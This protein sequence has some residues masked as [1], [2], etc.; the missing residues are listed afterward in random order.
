MKGPA[1]RASVLVS[2]LLMTGA[3]YVA[4]A[5]GLISS[6]LVAR[7]L[8]PSDYG[9]YAYVLWLC[10]VLVTLM[11][12]G[13]TTSAIRF[14]SESRGRGDPA[15]ADALHN[16]FSRGQWISI[17]VVLVGFVAL[18]PWL[19][20]SGW[21]E[22][23]WLFGA[24]VAVATI[25]KTRYVFDVSICKGHSRF[26]IE[27]M[28]IS[29]LAMSS[30]I[31][32][33]VLWF[34]DAPLSSYLLLFTAVCI[35]HP[36]FSWWQMRRAGI[37]AAPRGPDREQLANVYPHLYWTLVL[38]L[39]GVLGNRTAETF[40]LNRYENAESIAFFSIA[41]QLTRA[42][43][44]MLSIG[45]TTVLMPLMAHGFGSGGQ[46]KAQS[47]ASD[48][49]RS[50]HFMGMLLVGVGLLWAEPIVMLLYGRAYQPAV[51]VLQ[52]LI[53][54]GGLTLSLAALGSLLSVT[55]NQRA[56]AVTAL[57]AMVTS[58]V[59]ALVLVPR[60]GLAGAVAS[61]AAASFANLLIT[62]LVVRKY[63][64][65]RMPWRE[66][67]RLSLAAVVAFAATGWVLALPEAPYA[68]VAAGVV[69]LVAFPTATI[70]LRAWRPGDI[71]L[72]EP[73]LRRMPRLARWLEK[74]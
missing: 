55:D 2:V 35:V 10:T 69:Y 68:H 53:V 70:L 19:L 45:L 48:A 26:S 9:R 7:G 59:L 72:L 40:L 33:A 6:T 17:V 22:S 73:L 39:V 27:A 51:A 49:I 38:S 20:P 28:S 60:Y 57:V 11:N 63:F 74:R 13:L 18:I 1:G 4:Y 65:M 66:L 24:V 54:V 32:A 56:R 34:F 31:G 42:G 46:E 37:R 62:G 21:S 43:V 29:L 64:D 50:Y 47:I 12:H 16:W 5:A 25:T 61:S 36:I 41:T 8:G 14:V 3:T 44:D 67:G 71:R 30:A 58:I 23:L 15:L 52:A